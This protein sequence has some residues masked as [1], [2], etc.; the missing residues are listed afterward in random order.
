M[1]RDDNMN[2]SPDV[3][4]EAA[5]SSVDFPDSTCLSMKSDNSMSIRNDFKKRS[6]ESSVD[7]P[8][9]SCLSMESDNSMHVEQLFKK[10]GAESSV[11]SEKSSD[12]PA[13]SCLS[14]KSDRSMHVRKKLKK[15]HAESSRDQHGCSESSKMDGNAIFKLVEEHSV[16]ILL[17]ELKRYKKMLF[18]HLS[19]SENEKQDEDKT[20]E[21]SCSDGVLKIAL[22][23][24]KEMG[25]TELANKLEKGKEYVCI[26]YLCICM[27]CDMLRNAII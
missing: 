27:I 4:Q 15:E 8:A 22:H 6:A 7:F 1:K 10:E 17:S 5:Q 23:V 11:D 25:Q 16:N 13:S 18:P 9:S 14:S 12:F 26:I 19:Q 3:T 2:I 20:Q 24:L 21:T